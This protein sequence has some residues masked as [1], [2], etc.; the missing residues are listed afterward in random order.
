MFA[1]IRKYFDTRKVEKKKRKRVLK[2]IATG[3]KMLQENGYLPQ[4]R[5]D[6][7]RFLFSYCVYNFGYPRR[8]Y[9]SRNGNLIDSYAQLI[10]FLNDGKCPTF[11]DDGYSYKY[12]KFELSREE[13]RE[14]RK[15]D[16][17]LTLVMEKLKS[18]TKNWMFDWNVIKNST[19]F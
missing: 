4:Y 15:D 16:N 1:K 13:L 17:D 2:K 12:L 14:I 9:D 7:G 18:E 5:E 10:L 11:D 8:K 6:K 19:I 3:A